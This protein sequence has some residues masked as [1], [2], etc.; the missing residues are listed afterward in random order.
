MGKNN[1]K[2]NRKSS[3]QSNQSNSHSSY[4]DEI[5]LTIRIKTAISLD[6]P[7]K[8]FNPPLNVNLTRIHHTHEIYTIENFLNPIECQ[9]FIAWGEQFGFS[10]FRQPETKE[11]A[12]REVDEI[13]IEST[14]VADAIFSRLLPFLPPEI[15]GMRPSGMKYGGTTPILFLIYLNRLQK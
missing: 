4:F 9:K 3:K 14:A 15:D 13:N 2:N 11:Y 10:E 1:T 5:N 7:T 6:V 8:Y 12:H